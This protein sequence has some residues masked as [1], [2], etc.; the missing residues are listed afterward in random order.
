MSFL[1]EMIM[2]AYTA[3]MMSTLPEKGGNISVAQNTTT[4]SP[5]EVENK[6]DFD[7]RKYINFEKFTIILFYFQNN[8]SV[9]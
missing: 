7:D 3:Q 8:F 2:L 5:M 1:N 9:V 6:F 4:L